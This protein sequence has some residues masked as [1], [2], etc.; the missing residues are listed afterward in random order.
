MAFSP[1]DGPASQDRVAVTTGTVTELKVAASALADRQV[2]TVQPVDGNIWV[3]FGNGSSTPSAATVSAKG[4]KVV[5]MSKESFEA[6]ERQQLFIVAESGT[7]NV[8]FTE[9]A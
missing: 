9:R 4:F 3:Y 2:I 6:G 5:K 8:T 7:V 1:L